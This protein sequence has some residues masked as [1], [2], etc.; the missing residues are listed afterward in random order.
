VGVYITDSTLTI[1]NAVWD[2]PGYK[3]GAV[4]DPAGT[5]LLCE[6]PNQYNLAGNVWPSYCVGPG[7][8]IPTWSASEGGAYDNVQASNKTPADGKTTYGAALFG[9]HDR[10]FNYLFHDGHVA[11]LRPQDTVGG[12]TTNNPLG[13]W[14]MVKGD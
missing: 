6:L 9:L 3:S 2:P 10:R 4:Q 8:N 12:G 5:I 11:T 13:M 7:Y 14:T 1:A